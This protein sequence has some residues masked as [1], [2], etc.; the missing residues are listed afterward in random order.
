M[1]FVF[2]NTKN[3][4][5]GDCLVLFSYFTIG[6]ETEAQTKK[7]CSQTQV[8]EF[9]VAQPKFYSI[10]KTSRPR[11]LPCKNVL[12]ELEPSQLP[13]QLCRSN[14]WLDCTGICI[15]VQRW[16]RMWYEMAAAIQLWSTK[17]LKIPGICF[18][19]DQPGRKHT[20]ISLSLR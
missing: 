17:E 8:T 10:L 5:L 16:G 3:F 4:I 1:Q 12:L 6:R 13:T 7:W 19:K 2:S 20:S 18:N 9:S 11:F 14:A 15:C